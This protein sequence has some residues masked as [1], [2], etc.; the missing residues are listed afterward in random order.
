MSRN[1]P[2]LRITVFL[3]ICPF[4]APLGAYSRLNFSLFQK[5]IIRKEAGKIKREGLL[6]FSYLITA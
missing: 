6:D 5:K 4:K 2:E 3:R 1:L